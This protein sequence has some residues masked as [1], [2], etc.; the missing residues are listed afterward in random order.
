MPVRA[1][2]IN[3]QCSDKTKQGSENETEAAVRRDLDYLLAILEFV[4][5]EILVSHSSPGSEFL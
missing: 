2:V 3:T 1:A 4:R 5:A